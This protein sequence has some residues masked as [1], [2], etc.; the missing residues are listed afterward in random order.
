MN[1]YKI[2]TFW[3]PK[4][5]AF[6]GTCPEFE[7]IA[8][9]GKTRAIAA[10]EAEAALA[11]TI[12]IYQEEGIPLPKP[13]EVLEYSGQV[14]L[15]MSKY[16]HQKAAERAEAGGV[17]LNSYLSG[18]VE[19]RLAVEDYQQRLIDELNRRWTIA[20]YK[21][22]SWSFVRILCARTIVRTDFR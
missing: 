3:S 6:I 2:V 13:A 20:F 11:D 19:A 17:S 21:R 7:G 9:V 10:K 22:L 12:E 18:A 8:V 5:N 16:V 14:R 4:D 1:D 15:R